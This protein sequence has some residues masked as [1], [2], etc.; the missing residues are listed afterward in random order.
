MHVFVA[1]RIAESGGKE[2]ADEL[3][4]HGYAK[5]GEAAQVPAGQD[6]PTGPVLPGAVTTA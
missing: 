5:Y 6:L 1:G 3:E 2:L 4:A